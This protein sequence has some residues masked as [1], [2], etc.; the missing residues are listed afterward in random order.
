[1]PSLIDLVKAVKNENLDEINLILNQTYSLNEIENNRNAIYEAMKVACSVQTEKSHSISRQLIQDPQLQKTLLS[2]IEDNDNEILL[3]A[4]ENN[5]KA[6][7]QLLLTQHP[8][9]VKAHNNNNEALELACKKGDTDTVALLLDIDTVFKKA[10]SNKNFSLIYAAQHGHLD[11]VNLLLSVP[12]V[13]E[14]ANSSKNAALGAAAYGNHLAIVQVLLKIPNVKEKVTVKHNQV[15]KSALEGNAIETLQ[16]LLSIDSVQNKLLKEPE[17]LSELCNNS[18]LFSSLVPIVM[19]MEF[20]GFTLNNLVNASAKATIF[21]NTQD[22]LRF[23]SDPVAFAKQ[24]PIESTFPLVVEA[25]KINEVNNRIQQ[26]ESAYRT[27]SETAMSDRALL[28]AKIGFTKAQQLYMSDFDELVKEH[29][30]PIKAIEYIERNIRDLILKSIL[31]ETTDDTVKVFIK[32]NH[33]KLLNGDDTSLMERAREF[34]KSNRN[35]NHIAWRAYDRFAPVGEWPNLLTPPLNDSTI[36]AAGVNENQTEIDLISGSYDVRFRIALYY[37]ALKDLAIKPLLH[38]DVRES[39]F[40]GQIADIRRA[41][42]A[43]DTM[44]VDDPSCYPGTIG[45]IATMGAGHP[46]L[47]VVDPVSEVSNVVF[48]LLSNFCCNMQDASPSSNEKI[49][50][51]LTALN[52]YSIEMLREGKS[53]EFNLTT[54]TE[55]LSDR[56]VLELRRTLIEKLGSVAQVFKMINQDFQQRNPIIRC[57]VDDE[58]IYVERQLV[59]IC[60][61]GVANRI[62]SSLNP[63]SAKTSPLVINCDD[64]FKVALI[65]KQLR[66]VSDKARMLGSRSYANDEIRIRMSFEMAQ[67]QHQIYSYVYPKLLAFYHEVDKSALAAFAI[68]ITNLQFK[69]YHSVQDMHNNWKGQDIPDYI[70]AQA[71]LEYQSRPLPTWPG[72]DR[73]DHLIDHFK[74]ENLRK[75]LKKL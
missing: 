19:Q 2:M 12:K 26:L 30:T 48:R 64:P 1:M 58:K 4:I 50:L 35:I 28:A 41:H 33:D 49:C 52:Q 66:E 15:L 51:A 71:V 38:Q 72:P 70:F 65:E 67:C 59:D 39:I 40:I 53:L 18:A 31:N 68:I 37:L 14:K 3:L 55:S 44:S 46:E 32:R 56:Q 27:H 75:S 8:I 73:L 74:I 54:A 63:K 20:Y 21:A 11:V 16:Y 5:H 42:N 22:I 60:Y 29:S 9:K 36:F 25:L 47:H 6:T 34:F 61:N 13:K 23:F 45:R 57:L 10:H 69:Q 62:A 7:A 24:I 17:L 43:N